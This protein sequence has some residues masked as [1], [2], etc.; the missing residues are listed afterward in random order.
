[1]LGALP[2]EVITD[3][4]VRTQALDSLDDLFLHRLAPNGGDQPPEHNATTI[5][6][7]G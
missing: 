1:M 4:A 3:E 6:A 5:Q 2:R 7:V